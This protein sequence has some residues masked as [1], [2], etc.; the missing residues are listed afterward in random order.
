VGGRVSVQT[1]LS[2]RDMS[3]VIIIVASKKS[4][5]QHMGQE[6]NGSIFRISFLAD[7]GGN[8]ER[9][10]GCMGIYTAPPPPKKKS[11][12]RLFMG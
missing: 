4:L 9:S 8:Q 11:P 12:S 5:D 6:K 10:D 7:P 1:I 2:P 3:K